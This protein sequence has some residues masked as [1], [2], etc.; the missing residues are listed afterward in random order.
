M[1]GYFQAHGE[2]NYQRRFVP[3]FWDIFLPILGLV[4]VQQGF[5]RR[6]FLGVPSP[7][8]LEEDRLLSTGPCVTLHITTQC[9]G[10]VDLTT[11]QSSSSPV[12][13]VGKT[14]SYSQDLCGVKGRRRPLLWPRW[15]QRKAQSRTSTADGQRRIYTRGLF[16]AAVN[17][18]DH[19]SR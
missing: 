4:G 19:P 9:L 10:S 3:S 1:Q 12:L 18:E 8:F 7:G 14:S 5:A 13:N 15:Q 6:L 17:K 16:D 2:R 11:T